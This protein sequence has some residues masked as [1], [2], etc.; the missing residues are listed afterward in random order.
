MF[1]FTFIGSNLWFILFNGSVILMHLSCIV[2]IHGDSTSAKQNKN[3]KW[4]INNTPQK[5]KIDTLTT[6]VPPLESLW[7]LRMIQNI[8]GRFLGVFIDILQLNPPWCLQSWTKGLKVRTVQKR[9]KR[10]KAP[11][12]KSTLDAPGAGSR[13]QKK[14][15]VDMVDFLSP[16][17]KLGHDFLVL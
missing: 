1:T 14:L 7:H 15:E 4:A 8:L 3:N 5:F 11:M 17:K 9:T 2:Y 12:P 6:D 10:Q 13:A 16:K